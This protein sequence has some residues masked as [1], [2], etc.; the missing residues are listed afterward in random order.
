MSSV[1]KDQAKFM[2]A[3]DQTVD[4]FNFDQFNLY[5]GLIEEEYN[6]LKEAIAANDP[7]EVLDAL[8]DILVVT[9]GAM[10]S[11]GVECDKVWAEI[12]RSNMSKVDPESGKVLKR[13]DGKVLKPASFSP[14]DL[15][16]F[17]KQ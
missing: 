12:I 14:P 10:L 6:E 8:G 2:I 1:F 9:I 4:Q 7:V 5:T 17:I 16:Q 11:M 3:G 15:T 13:E